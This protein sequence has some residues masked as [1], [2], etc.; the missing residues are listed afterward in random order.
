MLIVHFGGSLFKFRE[1]VLSGSFTF[2]MLQKRNI[3]VAEFEI[4]G[5]VLA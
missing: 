4:R 1:H 2:L 3:I 5:P